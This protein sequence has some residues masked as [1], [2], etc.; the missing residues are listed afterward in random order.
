MAGDL[1]SLFHDLLMDI[2]LQFEKHCHRHFPMSLKS[3]FVMAVY[4]TKR[5]H[6]IL[7]LDIV[8]LDITS[9]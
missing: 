7:V 1:L 2:E 4:A 6:P 5:I 8:L 3:L 9:K